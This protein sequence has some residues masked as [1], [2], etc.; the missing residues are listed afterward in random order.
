MSQFT[1]HA[2]RLKADLINTDALVVGPQGTNAGGEWTQSSVVLV[3]GS[4]GAGNANVMRHVVIGK[5][6]ICLIALTQV[7]SAGVASGTLE[8][9]LPV[10]SRTVAHV[11]GT[12]LLVTSSG[13]FAITAVSNE[14]NPGRLWLYATANGSGP[15]VISD[16][17]T[18]GTR[19]TQNNWLLS[20][21][22][23]Y[24]IA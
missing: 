19:V 13:V 17:S 16:A 20:L 14:S 18:A 4:L 3:G 1:E 5:T 21:Q 9:T 10:P 6:C 11:A 7:A 12:G 23:T 2:G 15:E 8:L 24:E 22:L